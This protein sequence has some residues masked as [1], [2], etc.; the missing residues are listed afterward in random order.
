MTALFQ[1]RR[2]L[3]KTTAAGTTGLLFGCGGGGSSSEAAPTPT[4]APTP[5]PVATPAPTPAA[6]PAPEGA[7]RMP[8]EAEPHKATWMAY[9]DSPQIWGSRLLAGVQSS[10]AQIANTIV[11]F[12]PVNMLV[13]AGSLAAARAKLDPRVNLIVAEIDDLWV[14]DTGCV[15]VKKSD[16]TRAAVNFNFNGWG[17]KQTFTRDRKVAAFMAN[18]AGVPLLASDLVL[19]GG[20]IEV[21]GKGTAI[22]T[23]SCVLNNNRNPSLSKAKCE[24]ELARVLGIQKVIWLPGIAGKDITDGHTDFYARF[25]SPSVVIAHVDPFLDSYD[26]AVTAKHLEILRAAKD[27]VGNALR[28]E[29][30]DMPRQTRQP[31]NADFTAGYVN[32]YVCNGAVIAPEFGDTSYD[33][34]AQALLTKEYPGRKIIAINIDP[35]AEGGGGIHCATQQEIA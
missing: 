5:A 20:A 28:I 35:I 30:A 6:T 34:R 3:L 32:F 10:L 19:E 9:T 8:D 11:A 26:N 27:S 21:D 2:L 17:S 14:R 18:H 25:A 12:E 4:A 24:Q 29:I 15:F 13:N 31:N 22:I 16:G 23:E 7:Y 33:A 1:K